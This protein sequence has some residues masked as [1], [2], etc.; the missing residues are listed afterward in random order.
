VIGHLKTA[1]LALEAFDARDAA[2]SIKVAMRAIKA[3]IDKLPD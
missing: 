3:I 2:P 1:V